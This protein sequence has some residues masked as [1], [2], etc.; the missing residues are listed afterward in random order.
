[1][2]R[3]RGKAG[4]RTAATARVHAARS[5]APFVP[6]GQEARSLGEARSLAPARVHDAM[7]QAMTRFLVKRLSAM[8]VAAAF[9]CVDEDLHLAD[10]GVFR[11]HRTFVGRDGRV[12]DQCLGW[13]V[14]VAQ[15]GWASGRALVQRLRDLLMGDSPE[16]PGAVPTGNHL[17]VLGRLCRVFRVL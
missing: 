8:V 16:F 9:G 5:A 12:W 15:D 1:M 2:H 3:R 4:R 6:A 11:R 14:Y 13:Y 7:T 10:C 17:V